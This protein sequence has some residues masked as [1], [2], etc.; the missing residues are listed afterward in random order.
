MSLCLSK[1]RDVFQQIM[2][3]HGVNAEGKRLPRMAATLMMRLAPVR[4]PSFGV[5]SA[6]LGPNSEFEDSL[7]T[8]EESQTNNPELCDIGDI[9]DPSAVGS[10]TLE[11]PSLES[12]PQVEDLDSSTGSSVWSLSSIIGGETTLEGLEDTADGALGRNQRT[13]GLPTCVF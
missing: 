10:L 5:H 8:G 1:L 4:E 7:S 2:A 9:E 12:S 3:N 6:S 11:L 13:G